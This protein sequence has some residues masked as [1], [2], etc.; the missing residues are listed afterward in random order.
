MVATAAAAADEKKKTTKELQ[1]QREKTEIKKNTNTIGIVL[2]LYVRLA[3]FGFFFVVF[4]TRY[5][6]GAGRRWIYTVC[7][8]VQCEIQQYSGSIVP[9]MIVCVD[10]TWSRC[11]NL[12]I[13]FFVV[14]LSLAEQKWRHI[15]INAK[16]TLPAYTYTPA[17]T[18]THS[19]G[20]GNP[21]FS[22]WI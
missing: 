22:H 9:K 6:A 13:F 11:R 2:R 21:Q 3:Y 8:S 17:S 20:T 18:H 19:G 15:E 10:V 4:S 14:R 1:Q 7:N 16:R 12:V 5:S